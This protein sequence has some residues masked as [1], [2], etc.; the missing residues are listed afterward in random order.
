MNLH[1]T[2]HNI[3]VGEK[4]NIDGKLFT[5]KKYKHLHKY[6]PPHAVKSLN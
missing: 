2:A 1:K 5:N 4:V 3:E 6:S